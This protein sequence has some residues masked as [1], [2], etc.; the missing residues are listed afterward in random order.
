[1]GEN[2]SK[3]TKTTRVHDVNRHTEAEVVEDSK[4]L[5]KPSHACELQALPYPHN[6]AHTLTMGFPTANGNSIIIIGNPAA[7]E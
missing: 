4:Q 7:I 3:S 2:E 6:G 1:M 5:S